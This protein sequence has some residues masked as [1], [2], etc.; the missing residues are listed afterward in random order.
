M[1]PELGY[2]GESRWNSLQCAFSLSAYAHALFSPRM[3]F[4][5]GTGLGP[6]TEQEQEKAT[7][8]DKKRYQ[9]EFSHPTLLRLGRM[10]LHLLFCHVLR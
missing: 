1:R 10:G 8:E 9:L 5:A 4:F 3:D 6:E 2:S 7:E